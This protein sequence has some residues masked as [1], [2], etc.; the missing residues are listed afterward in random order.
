MREVLSLAGPDTR[1]EQ[2]KADFTESQSNHSNVGH[3]QKKKKITFASNTNIQIFNLRLP[4][5][6]INRNTDTKKTILVENSHKWSR[7]YNDN[8]E[9]N[10]KSSV[11]HWQRPTC[12]QSLISVVF[13][14]IHYKCVNEKNGIPNLKITAWVGFAFNFLHPQTFEFPSK[15][16][17]TKSFKRVTSESRILNIF[18]AL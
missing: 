7:W 5:S 10:G 18:Q 13:S 3:T 4:T 12:T 15:F 6:I 1:T 9:Y 17:T 16:H 8:N 14:L 2:R 11:K